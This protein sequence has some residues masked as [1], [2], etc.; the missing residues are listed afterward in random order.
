MSGSATP[1]A[2]VV[3]VAF[4]TDH[5]RF[6]LSATLP[7]PKA[8]GRFMCCAFDA[9]RRRVFAVIGVVGTPKCIIRYGTFEELAAGRGDEIDLEMEH[10]PIIHAEYLGGTDAE[11]LLLL[12]GRGNL[13][14]VDLGSR[15]TIASFCPESPVT[16]L[17]T[18]VAQQPTT[19][20]AINDKHIYQCNLERPA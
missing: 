8:Q 10:E 1:D 2:E 18:R 15:R 17:A 6:D 7:F 12:S 13:F 20:C 11:C 9:L 16:R 3:V 19:Y 4:R 14:V 5:G